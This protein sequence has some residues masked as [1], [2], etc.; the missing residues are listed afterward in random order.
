MT[1]DGDM[2]DK[3]ALDTYGRTSG[4]TEALMAANPH[5]AGQLS[6]LPAGLIVNLPNLPVP[7]PKGTV[8][9]WD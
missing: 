4:A 7:A 5:L 3:I 9:L 6:R 2:L 8:R 1:R